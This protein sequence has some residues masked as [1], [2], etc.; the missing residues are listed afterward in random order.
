MVGTLPI[1]KKGGKALKK[2]LLVPVV[3]ILMCLC[4]LPVYADDPDMD[5]D[6]S[7]STPGDV[8]LD[9]GINAGGDVDV[10]V[11]G[12]DF[13]EVANTAH[14]AMA[15]TGADGSGSINT[16]DWWRYKKLYLDPMFQD[17]FINANLTN[18]QM[19]VVTQAIAKLIRENETVWVSIN[20]T[21]KRME[22]YLSLIRENSGTIDD[23][24]AEDD[25]MYTRLMYG[26]EAHI[27]LLDNRV[28]DEVFL[29]KQENTRL[30]YCLYGLGGCI[31]LIGI[32][33]VLL[34]RK[35]HYWR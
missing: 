24:L 31:V 9:V 15:N 7:V 26:A 10:T 14:Q 3:L 17:L 25:L 28:S 5:V 16:D 6:V 22:N 18:E 23:L 11:D 30:Y 27:A 4:A 2:L 8:D 35:R 1:N 32:A 19:D 20:A 12:V 33:M 29:L 34:N 13:Q 21:D